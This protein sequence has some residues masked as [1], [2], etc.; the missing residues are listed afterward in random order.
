MHLFFI[1]FAGLYLLGNV[2]IYFRSWELLH[3]LS[4]PMRW[5]LSIAYWAGCCSFF[6][7]FGNRGLPEAGGWMHML[8]YFTTSWL[9]FTLYMVLLLLFTDVLRLFHVIINHRFIICFSLTLIVLACGYLRYSHPDT[10]VINININKPVEGNKHLRVVAV[11]DIHLGYGTNKARLQHYLRMIK[12]AR[13]DLILISGDLIDSTLKPVAEERME[14]EL[15]ALEA[16]LGVYMVPGNHDH[17]CGIEACT[18]F[19]ARTPITLLR[20]SVARLECGIQIVGRDDNYNRRRKPLAQL[21][22]ETDPDKP[23][24]VM[25][26]QPND[27]QVSAAID[28]RADL[29]LCGHTHNGQVWPF[30]LATKSI[31]S[32]SYGYDKVQG[33]H[34]Y[35]SSGLGLWGPPYR[36]GSDSELAVIDMR[37]E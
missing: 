1:V 5:I 24:I 15:R 32:H 8:Y 6:G 4:L 17:L 29:L 16:P 11:S 20:D 31:Y 12:E 23:V 7:F 19:V 34:I 33:T 35:V 18:Q 26:H 3:T 25:D 30:G 37:T 2:Y 14:K 10:K 28:S 36:I 27:S 13:P 22:S 21:M 9:V